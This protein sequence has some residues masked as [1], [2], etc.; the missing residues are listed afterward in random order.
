LVVEGA[1]RTCRTFHTGE[2]TI[3]AFYLPGEM[4]GWTSDAEHSFSVEATTEA[5]I[6][7]LKRSSLQSLASSERRVANFL[8][9]V[10]TKELRRTQEYAVWVRQNSKSRVAAFLNDL[11]LRLGCIR[12]LDL[13]MS[14]DD[15]AHHLGLTAETLS[16]S[17]T[18][19]ERIGVVSR[20]NTHRLLIRNR[21]ELVRIATNPSRRGN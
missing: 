15:I 9:A 10:T 17:L 16:R 5:L 13:P 19:L 21:V 12:H 14:H 11:W 7:F 3:V 4:F 1:V 2:R 20:V 18:W 6:L 8:H